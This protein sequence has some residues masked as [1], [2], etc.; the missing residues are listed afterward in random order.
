MSKFGEYLIKARGGISQRKAARQI[1]ISHTF[2]GNMENGKDPR[3]GKEI[4]PTPETLKLIS[5]AYRCDYEELMKI[6]GY[7]DESATSNSESPKLTQHQRMIYQ[8]AKKHDC[9]FESKSEVEELIEEFEIVYELFKKRKQR[10]Y[11]SL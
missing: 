6:A 1:G 9:F 3:T 8:W 7:I 11:K 4:K 10:N 5:K 2:L